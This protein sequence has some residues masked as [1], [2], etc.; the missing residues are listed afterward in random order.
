MQMVN[1]FILKQH[2]AGLHVI[3]V[4]GLVLSLLHLATLLP[5]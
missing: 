5:S 1:R 2:V 3:I 4:D